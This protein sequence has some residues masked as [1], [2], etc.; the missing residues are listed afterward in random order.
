MRT[1]PNY[2]GSTCQ[3]SQSKRPKWPRVL[4]EVKI[5]YRYT[6]NIAADFITKQN[7][8]CKVHTSNLSYEVKYIKMFYIY[9]S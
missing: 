7:A 4:M 2:T 1:S 9:E 6:Q 8:K 5:D 3:A